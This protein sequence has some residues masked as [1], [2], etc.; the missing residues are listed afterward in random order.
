MA[1]NDLQLQY[2]EDAV[3]DGSMNHAG[4]GPESLFS[5]LFGGGGRG[6]ARERRGENVTHPLKV[7]LE[8]CYNGTIR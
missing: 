1:S 8:E 6:R 4:G 2:G 3:K 5:E 7:S